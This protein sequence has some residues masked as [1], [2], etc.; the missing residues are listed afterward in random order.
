MSI[1]FSTLNNVFYFTSSYVFRNWQKQLALLLFCFSVYS[2]RA[3]SAILLLLLNPIVDACPP[4]SFRP[5]SI[6]D[7]FPPRSFPTGVH[8]C[9]PSTN[10]HNKLLISTPIDDDTIR[11]FA[12]NFFHSNENNSFRCLNSLNSVFVR[13]LLKLSRI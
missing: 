3:C 10:I 5:A 13:L 4:R 12:V 8:R 2:T 7:A 6:V 9:R 1:F 11:K